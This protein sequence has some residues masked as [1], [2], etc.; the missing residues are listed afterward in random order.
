[1]SIPTPPTVFPFPLHLE[2]GLVSFTTPICRPERERERERG[3]G[4]RKKGG[5]EEE[6]ERGRA[7]ERREREREG[8]TCK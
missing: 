1:M 2:Y 3:G 4:G 7:E 8:V 6:R 5:R